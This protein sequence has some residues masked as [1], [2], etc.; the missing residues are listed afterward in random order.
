M[1][2]RGIMLKRKKL[3]F[4]PVEHESLRWVV[5]QCDLLHIGKSCENGEEVMVTNVRAKRPPGLSTRTEKPVSLYSWRN[6]CILVGIV[7]AGGSE[8]ALDSP[9]PW[10]FLPINVCLG[11]HV[12]ILGLRV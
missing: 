12:L 6:M 4:A 9:H 8:K 1:Y 2:M 5:R 3:E 10:P 11:L 7:G